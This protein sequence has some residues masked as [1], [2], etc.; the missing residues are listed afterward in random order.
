MPGSTQPTTSAASSDAIPT[1][2]DL[3]A[4]F[5]PEYVRWIRLM[6]TKLGVNELYIALPLIVS[7][8]YC[9]QHSSARYVMKNNAGE[10]VVLHEEPLILYGLVAGESGTNKSGAIKILMD[11]IDGIRNVHGDNVDHSLDTFSHEARLSKCA[12]GSAK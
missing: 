7:V 1:E 4:W 2:S 11:L 6:S 5:P 8:A 3:D 12:I 9:T 10:D